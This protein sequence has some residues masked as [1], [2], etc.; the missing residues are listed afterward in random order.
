MKDGL[1]E[2]LEAVTSEAEADALRGHCEEAKARY[3]RE[4]VRVAEERGL[5]ETIEE[6]ASRS[7]TK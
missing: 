6:V 1:E 4:L 3:E 7:P 5:S 2:Q